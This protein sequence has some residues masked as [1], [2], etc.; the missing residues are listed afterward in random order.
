MVSKY[1]YGGLALLLVIA[2]IYIAYLRGANDELVNKL[3]TANAEKIVAE[4]E[5]SSCVDSTNRQ[6]KAVV[7]MKVENK[8]LVATIKR[9]SAAYKKV[10]KAG[11]I[12]SEKLKNW[13]A[14][15]EYEKYESVRSKIDMKLIESEECNEIKKN[16]KLLGSIKYSDL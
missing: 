6:N 11:K 16:L 5:I 9:Q 4:M 12:A 15:P 8:K 2:G 10:Q 7:A 3:N 1:I 14:L 13:E